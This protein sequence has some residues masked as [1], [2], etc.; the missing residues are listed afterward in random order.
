MFYAKVIL[1]HTVLFL[2]EV[3]ANVF[4]YFKLSKEEDTSINL[5]N[6]NVNIAMREE[7][8]DGL[9]V[10]VSNVLK[11]VLFQKDASR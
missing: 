8:L 9:K 5:S 4:T 1:W 10:L 3:F 2:R 7:N 11:D 6:T